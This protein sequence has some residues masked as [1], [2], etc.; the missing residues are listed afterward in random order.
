[1]SAREQRLFCQIS[2]FEPLDSFDA[3]LCAS[4]LFN[5]HLDQTPDWDL[6]LDLQ[7][8]YTK[9]YS[10]SYSYTFTPSTLLFPF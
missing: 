8:P 2:L 1:M 5:K 10:Y 3:T 6:Q 7:L 9:N 4:A